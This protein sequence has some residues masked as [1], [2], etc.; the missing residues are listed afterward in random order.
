MLVLVMDGLIQ[1]YAIHGFPSTF[2][3]MSHQLDHCMLLLLNGHTSH[4]EP[5]VL[6][7]AAESVWYNHN[8]LTA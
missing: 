2:K 5:S 3:L 7:L 6:H 1:K 4:F 8:S